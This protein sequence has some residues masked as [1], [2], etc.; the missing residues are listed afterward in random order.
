MRGADIFEQIKNKKNMKKF[1]QFNNN[2][3]IIKMD[4]TK[5]EK[6]IRKN[7]DLEQDEEYFIVVNGE[8]NTIFQKEFF[9]T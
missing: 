3:H 7:P 8:K 2:E 5:L 4:I 6:I 9:L 1:E